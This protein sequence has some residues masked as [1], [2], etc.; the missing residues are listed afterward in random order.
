MIEFQIRE[1]KQLSI[2]LE[3]QL[4]IK[5]TSIYNALTLLQEGNTIPFIA[6]YRKEHTNNLDDEQLRQILKLKNELVSLDERRVTIFNTLNELGIDDQALVKDI[7]EADTLSRLEDLY[8]PYKPKKK[9]RASE[10]IR[11]GL[12]P[13]SELILSRAQE[14]ELEKAILEAMHNCQ[15]LVDENMCL[16][17]AKDII[18]QDVS[19]DPKAR[20]YLKKYIYNTGLLVTKALKEE[21]SVYSLYYDFKMPI[22]KLKGYQILAINRAINQEYLKFYFEVDQIGLNTILDRQLKIKHDNS[23]CDNLLIEV[24]KDAYQRLIYPSLENEIKNN[25]IEQAFKQALEIFAKNLKSALLVPPIKN[26]VVL[27]LDPGYYNGCKYAVV[28]ENGDYLSSGLIYVAK[29]YE[30]FEEAQ[31]ILK[32]E[33][34]K[35]GIT[36]CVIG[37]GSACRETEAFFSNFINNEKLN[38]EYLLVDESGASVYS[39]TKLAQ[40]ELPNVALNNRSAVSLARRVLDPLAELVKID[41]KSIGVGQY[42]HDMNQKQLKEELAGVVENCVNQVGVNLN[43]A[44]ASLL[45]YVSGINSSLAS[46]IIKYRNE[47]GAFTARNQLK[48]VAKLGPKTFEQCAGFLRIL[49]GSNSLDATAIHPES[50]EIAQKFIEDFNLKLNQETNLTK[51]QIKEYSLKNNIGYETLLDI[52]D[53]IAK[54]NRDIRDNFP[55]PIL[56]AKIKSINDLSVGQIMTGVIRNIT[57]FGAFIDLGL[58]QDGLCHISQISNSFIKNPLDVL[59][60]GMV[61]KVKVIDIDLSKQKIQLSIKQAN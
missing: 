46:N 38:I 8:R 4:Q 20:T 27:A 16:S 3:K 24:L 17:G 61:V 21:D 53:A 39:A 42:Q 15:E 30:K 58:H 19:D 6:R 11:R 55:A 10:A 54:P 2:D 34:K 59:S 23:Y 31:K 35:Y 9:T 41:P 26:R 25:L 36:L 22:K 48:K 60:I 43:T 45:S 37:N 13:L 29:P 14:K 44:S 56:T 50:Y 40:E 57:S 18:A 32:A 12:K 47:I 1:N 5:H 28:S 7:L 52:N 33:I 51:D 49:N